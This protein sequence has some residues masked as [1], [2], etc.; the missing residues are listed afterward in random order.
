LVSHENFDWTNFL[1]PGT[2]NETSA[3]AAQ[4]KTLHL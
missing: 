2:M 3:S 1:R 4:N